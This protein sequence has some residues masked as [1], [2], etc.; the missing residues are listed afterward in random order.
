M[1]QN[2]LNSRNLGPFRN[3]H[4]Y[5]MYLDMLVHVGTNP[6]IMLYKCNI[7][8]YIILYIYKMIISIH[9]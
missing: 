1:F 5:A 9:D 6:A 3:L 2:E 7:Y 4:M 8:I